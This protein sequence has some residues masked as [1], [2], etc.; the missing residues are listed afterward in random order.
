M[1]VSKYIKFTL[2]STGETYETTNDNDGYKKFLLE[3]GISW[4]G[5]MFVDLK[6][7][8][9]G[10]VW[11]LNIEHP[12]TSHSAPCFLYG[13]LEVP[14]ATMKRLK[15]QLS[16]FKGGSEIHW[17]T[18]DSDDVAQPFGLVGNKNTWVPEG[19]YG[20]ELDVWDC[21]LDDGNW[22]N[23]EFEAEDIDELTTKSKSKPKQNN[24][25]KHKYYEKKKK[26]IEKYEGKVKKLVEE[27]KKK[28]E[29]FKE[30]ATKLTEA[31]K[32]IAELRAKNTDL[33]TELLQLKTHQQD[34]VD[35]YVKKIANSKAEELEQKTNYIVQQNAIIKKLEQEKAHITS[36]GSMVNPA[37]CDM[38]TLNY[39]NLMFYGWNKEQQIKNIVKH[40]HKITKKSLIA[41]YEDVFCEKVKDKKNQ[42]LPK[43][44]DYFIKKANGLAVVMKSKSHY[45]PKAKKEEVGGGGS[46]EDDEEVPEIQVEPE[47]HHCGGCDDDKPVDECHECETCCEVKCSGCLSSDGSVDDEVICN[48]CEHDKHL[49][50]DGSKYL[51]EPEPEPETIDLGLND[52]VSDELDEVL[53]GA[54]KI[55]IKVS[56]ELQKLQD[57]MKREA[58]ERELMAQEDVNVAMSK[59]EEKKLNKKQLILKNIEI[60]EKF[61]KGK[62][63]KKGFRA[64]VEKMVG[65]KQFVKTFK[66]YNKMPVDYVKKD[67]V[68]L[69]NKEIE[70]LKKKYI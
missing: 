10:N 60:W 38:P 35:E 25:I 40:I 36:T 23:V 65:K 42:T 2:P 44:Q 19:D 16:V 64:I 45:V 18:F 6:M 30:R 24:N 61:T 48:N 5:C 32:K 27:H 1:S 21:Y 59:K 39:K 29:K 54:D 67:C 22:N 56:P 11:E 28:E 49:T 46:G 70:A 34:K 3:K 58:E 47:T 55:I 33:S 37:L 50:P 17:D 63:T 52:D 15:G 26:Y 31:N 66:G 4:F 14:K 13:I 7:A 53:K 68:D 62:I 51:S 41:F 9:K 8:K 69:M 20:K 43:V 12:D 57:D